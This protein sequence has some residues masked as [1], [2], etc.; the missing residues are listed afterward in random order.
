MLVTGARA[1]KVTTSKRGELLVATGVEFVH[2]PEG[3]EA[4][5]VAKAKREV[6]LSSGAFQSPQL[7]ELSG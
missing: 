3:E 5:F 6:V 7:L 1:T 4:E 2:G